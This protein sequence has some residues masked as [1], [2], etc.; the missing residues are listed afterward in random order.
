MS[1]LVRIA[2]F[3]VENLDDKADLRPSLAERIAVLRPQ[4]VRVRADVLCL[5]EV[6]GQEAPGQPRSL[7]ALGKLVE[8]T[9]YENFH[10]VHTK[11]QKGEP[12]D[13]R[14]LVVLSRFP[15]QEHQQ[16]KNTSGAPAY[17]KVT[18]QPPETVARPVEWERPILYARLDMGGG[19]SLHLYNVHLKSKLPT[20]I[21]GQKKD[22]H[23]WK[24]A[25]GWAEGFFL[26]SMKRVGQALELRLLVDE[27][28]DADPG[29]WVATCGD[30]NAES[31]E[32]PTTAVRGPVEETG[33]PE[34]ATRVLVP[35][36]NTIP[37]SSRYSLLHLGRGLMLDH[38]FVSR[39]FAA[40]YRGAEIHNE[41][42]PD[43][44]GAFRTDVDF[45][46]SD[47]APVVAE[48]VIP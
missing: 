1:T 15:I 29:A 16:L 3:N 37:E 42:L 7:A 9:V 13:V 21:T 4:L 32:V 31:H 33:N 36:E 5:Q 39:A 20:Q 6:N 11:T 40:F 10:L 2:T 12:Y 47:H 27:V 43:E 48:F 46:E 28:F 8:G 18:A 38:I 22:Q 45:P 34:L 25:R 35:C 19:R 44:S 17:Q 23:T 30:F 26:S 41:I 24:S 14:N